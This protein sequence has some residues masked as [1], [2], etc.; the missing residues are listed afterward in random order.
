MQART[1]LGVGGVAG[2]EG[3][4]REAAGGVLAEAGDLLLGLREGLAAF[5]DKARPLG[6]EPERLVQAHLRRFQPRHDLFQPRES[7]LEGLR[8]GLLIGFLLRH[9]SAPF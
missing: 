6:V 2:F 3:L 4:G 8:L 5:L 1:L 9:E 7:L